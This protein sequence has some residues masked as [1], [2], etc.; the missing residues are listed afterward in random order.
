MTE[1]TYQ[2][3]IKEAFIKPIRS[4]LIV[5]DDYPT[6]HE[7]LMDDGA[8]AEKY[9]HKDWNDKNKRGKV[10]E[11]IEQFR[12]PEAPYLLDIH[13]GSSPS[14][15]TDE[16][17]VRILHQTDLLV[18]DYQL[19]KDLEGDGSAAVRIAREALMNKHFNLI[20]V[21]TQEDLERIFPEFLLGLLTPFFSLGNSDKPNDVLQSFLDQFEDDL[22][23]LVAEPQYA[24][25]RYLA[26][27]NCKALIGAIHKGVAP[28]GEVKAL[29]TRSK[30]H[31]R[32]W[33]DAVLHALQ[34][35]EQ[36][37]ET[38]FADADAGVSYWSDGPIKFI[39]AARGFVAFKSKDDP[40][41]LMPAMLRALVA[42]DPRPPRLMLTKLR[43][44]MNERGIEVQDDALGN[45]EIGAVWYRR[46]LEASERNLG[47]M[48]DRTVR[49][50]AELLMDKLLPNVASFA[51]KIRMVD[52]KR[53]ISEVILERFK[54]NL[55]NEST[56]NSAKMGHNAFVG[57]KPIKSA[58]LELGH[59]LRLGE[60][61]W[62]C[63]TPACDMV[64]KVHRGKPYDRIEGVKRFTALKLVPQKPTDGL[65][66]AS[67]GGQIFANVVTPSNTSER[68]AFAVASKIGA[69][70]AWMTMYVQDDGYLPS[71]DDLVCKVSYVSSAEVDGIPV[72]EMKTI[73]AYVCGMLRYE[74]ALE[75]QSRFITSQSRIGLDFESTQPVDAT[76]AA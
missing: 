65:A 52:V 6:F 16:R 33:L 54:V 55:D 36:A 72:P 63:L 58:H 60:D 18:L 41:E 14:E 10:R 39:R 12:T 69:S 45:P 20:L 21:H 4:V 49:N 34:I 5:D 27:V 46:L 68:M 2:E 47:I 73:D 50:H 64:P 3:L 24:S 1:Q 53:D 71:G 40:E 62:V 48:I 67:R 61:H 57:S 51:E 23:G 8:R 30:L 15:E 26:N 13:D 75:I 22:L 42:W 28:W 37:N 19:D 11:V 35:F 56:L 25:A 44:E 17:Q 74:Y 59:I 38:R 43:A 29:L 9:G 31:A 7:I 32:Q 76:G 70:P 66:M